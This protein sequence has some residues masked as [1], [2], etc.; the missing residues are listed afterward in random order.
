MDQAIIKYY[1]G[2]LRTGFQHAGSIERPSIFLDTVREK[3]RICGRGGDY[4]HLYISISCETI[5][6]IRYL[7]TCPPAANVAVEI[8]CSLIIGKALVEI[9]TV[10]DDSFCETLGSESEELREKATGLLELM[11]RGLARYRAEADGTATGGG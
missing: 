4:L 7:C 11:H 10:T 9:D 3:V 2:L 5:S 1:R 6:N 8:L